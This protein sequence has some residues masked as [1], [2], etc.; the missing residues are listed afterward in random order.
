MK[1]L[2]AQALGKSSNKESSECIN[3]DFILGS[4]AEVERLWSVCDNILTD[5]RKRMTPQ[6]FEALAF[7]RLNKRFWNQKHVSLAMA[8]A[9]TELSRKRAERDSVQLDIDDGNDEFWVRRT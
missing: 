7:L 1:K 2:I 4:A 6:L 8:M 3:C 5:Q 9:S